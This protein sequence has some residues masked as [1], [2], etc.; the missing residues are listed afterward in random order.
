[1]LNSQEKYNLIKSIHGIPMYEGCMIG[2]YE[3]V[4]SE[5]L[6][7][8]KKGT[9]GYMNYLAI[10]EVQTVDDLS[11]VFS[12]KGIEGL[13]QDAIRNSKVKSELANTGLN[14][15]FAVASGAGIVTTSAASGATGGTSL[16]LTVAMW[17]GFVTS[18]A[19]CTDGLYKLAM[20]GRDRKSV[21]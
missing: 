15:F 5:L 4:G 6:H 7:G 19:Q 12:G 10:V 17:G 21:V 14:C 3:D 13:S 8:G 11:I 18:T 9:S 16:L 20:M 1:M 2:L